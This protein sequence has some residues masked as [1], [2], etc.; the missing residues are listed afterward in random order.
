MEMARELT[1]VVPAPR[2]EKLSEGKKRR[3]EYYRR[4]REGIE[5]GVKIGI[6]TFDDLT[7]GIQ[8]HEICIWGGPTGGGKT[9]GMQYSSIS[10]YLKKRTVLFISLEVE[11]EQILR[12][13]DVMLA[14]AKIRYKALKALDL[15]KEEEEQWEK[16]LERA[17]SERLQ[18][19]IIIIDDIKN[20]SVDKVAAEALRYKPDV[21][22]VDYLEE[23]RGHRNNQSWE[24]VRDAGRGLKQFARKE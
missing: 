24:N 3:E 7:L 21:V 12:R 16:I 15:N 22:C 19:D 10:A 2:S 23:M 5:H 6:P 14:D 4:K 9:T 11:A 1:E 8:P 20:C 13:F 17:E 18:H